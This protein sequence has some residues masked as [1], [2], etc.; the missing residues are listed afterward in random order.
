MG[1]LRW[2]GGM[3]RGKADTPPLLG[4]FRSVANFITAATLFARYLMDRLRYPR[5][6]RIMMGNALIARL[7]YSLRQRGV[8]ILFGA[9]ITAV[10]CDPHG[11]ARARF[12]ADCHG[13][14]LSSPTRV[15]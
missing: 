11:V 10:L 9:A 1:G 3:R 12:P 4:R 2:G 6:T 5:G 15:A 7:F 13:I 8:P 14:P